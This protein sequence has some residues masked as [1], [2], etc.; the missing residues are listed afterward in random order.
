EKDLKQWI[1]DAVSRDVRRV[2]DVEGIGEKKSKALAK[3]GIFTVPDLEQA[4]PDE[5][6]DIKNFSGHPL[7][8]SE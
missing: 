5:I 7:N 1:G 4:D 2:D 8:D 3:E 6:N